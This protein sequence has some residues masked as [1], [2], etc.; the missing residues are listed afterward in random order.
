M[1]NG[2]QVSRMGWNR[3]LAWQS[4]SVNRQLLATILTVGGCTV[5]V[6]AVAAFK[7]VAIAYQFGTGD[8]LEAF[9]IAFL[10]PQF[11]ITLIAGSLNAAL[12]PTYIHVREHD[13]LA[14]AQSL[15]SSV[16]LWI[17]A[18][19]IGVSF[20]FALA[21]GRLV[22]MLA[23]GFGAD[24]LHL[25]GWLYYLLLPTVVFSGLTTTWGAVLNAGNRFVGVAMLPMVTSLVTLFA[26]VLFSQRWGI[27]ALAIG[28]VGGGLLEAVLLAWALSRIGIS[29]MPR[30]CGISAAVREVF[31][32]SIPV[33]TA[34]LLMGSTPIIGQSMAAMLGQGSV[35][36]FN[37][38]GKFTALLLGVGSTAIS[39]AVLPHFSRMV[40]M[41]DW[42]G[43]R[44]TLATYTRLILLVTLPLTI[45]LVYFSEPLTRVLFQ[46]GAFTDAD[47]L[48]VSRVQ[49]FFVLQIPVLSLGI[50]VVRLISAL[51]ANHVM[52]W[53]T[54]INL[55]L[56]I[57]LSYVLMQR[58][59]VEG[60]ALSVSLMHLA[61]TAYLVFM[62]W[63][64]TA[65]A[66]QTTGRRDE[67][68]R[69][70]AL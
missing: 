62:A 8:A 50:M 38:G 17:V 22:P 60:L 24:K 25:T 37:Y 65:A 16:A 29:C 11:A 5:L 35:A 57:L 12:I 52:M 46:R 28:T 9:V 4:K 10:I 58:M 64:L 61:S 53:G 66:E 47:T 45:L 7:E 26:L 39:T 49:A 14:A 54:V 19:L 68:A 51:K 67:P 40:A 69:R 48:L 27:Y 21:G 13:G 20:V 36:A 34:A 32:Q 30:W 2:L 42:G 44:H 70:E 3:W 6:K 41:N 33:I 56:N 23:S 63:R 43:V 18:L 31:R 15:F 59:G 1:P 55:C